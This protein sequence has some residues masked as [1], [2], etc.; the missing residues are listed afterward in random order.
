MEQAVMVREVPAALVALAVRPRHYWP[1]VLVV[2][3]LRV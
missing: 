1:V 2:R 3:A